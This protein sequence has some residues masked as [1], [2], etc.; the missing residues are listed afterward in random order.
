M[1]A[2]QSTILTQNTPS[3]NIINEKLGILSL[4]IR[5]LLPGTTY[6]II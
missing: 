3:T 2:K 6:L 5:V 4:R 1:Y